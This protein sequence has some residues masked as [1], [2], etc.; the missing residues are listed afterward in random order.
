MADLEF[1]A[2]GILEKE[3]VISGAVAATNLRAFQISSADL[4]DEL[5]DLVNLVTA[6]CPESDSRAVRLM[7]SIFG[8][9]EKFGGLVA[10]DHVEGVG[11]VAG[12]S[13]R[14]QKLFVK[15]PRLHQIFYP[16]V[17]VIKMSRFHLLVV[18]LRFSRRTINFKP[19]QVSST[20][21]TFTSTN[22]SGSATGRMTSSVRSVVTPADFFGHDTQ[23]VP[24]SAIL[25]R[26]RFSS[27][28]NPLRRVVKK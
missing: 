14:G 23:S 16:Q 2:F 5:S 13:E 24:V 28:S 18:N 22:P 9:P 21:H 12:K 7:M 27:F 19:D 15:L 1:V 26:R 10:S 3:C 25:P 4:A 17:N 8:K 20:A 6:V 11:A